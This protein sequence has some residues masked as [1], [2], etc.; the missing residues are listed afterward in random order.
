MRC[1]FVMLILV[2]II[3][4]HSVRWENV[5]RQY[6]EDGLTVIV[7]E[8]EYIQ[9]RSKVGHAGIQQSQYGNYYVRTSNTYLGIYETLEEAIAVR[10]ESIR[11]REA[12]TFK[13]WAEELRRKRS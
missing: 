1:K 3:I 11:Q 7:I 13:E 12:G 2:R 10:E 4:L 9:P 6:F 5:M 8:E